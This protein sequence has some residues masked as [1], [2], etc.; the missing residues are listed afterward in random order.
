MT[1]QDLPLFLTVEETAQLLR[2]TPRGIYAMAERG[3]LPG[4][5]RIG[6]RLLVQRDALLG[7][8]LESRAPSLKE[9]RR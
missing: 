7:W 9:V 8:L 2:T 5:T 3:R 1:P 6:R 4:T